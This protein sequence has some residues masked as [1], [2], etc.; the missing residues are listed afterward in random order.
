MTEVL[1]DSFAAALKLQTASFAVSLAC[2][3]R[4]PRRAVGSL[5]LVNVAP[6][7][8]AP[9]SDDLA[10]VEGELVGSVRSSNEFLTQAASHLLSAGGK[11]I[12]PTIAL[13]SGY[14]LDGLAPASEQVRTAACAV[15]LVH[16]GSL[17]HDDVIDEAATRRGVPTVNARW[18]NVVAI[19]AGDFL[20]AR[21]SEAAASLGA[22]VAALLA[23]TISELCRGQIEELSSVYRV[24]RTEDSYYSA[25]T[26][27][28]AALMATS[29]RISGLVCGASEATLDALTAFGHHTG[30][31]FQL[32]DDALDFVGDDANL[33]KRPGQDLAEGIYNLP[34]LRAL[35]RAP[36]LRAQLGAPI[37]AERL[38]ALRTVVIEAGGVDDTLTC[39]HDHVQKA[40]EALNGAPDLDE[41]VVAALST[42]VDALVD[43]DR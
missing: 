27:K 19:L 16:L 20:L 36:E 22:E 32:V 11:R 2:R 41:T 17:Y 39:A 31:C 6:P 10:Q 14:A 1:V 26:G 28:T 3:I 21:A 25:I 37:E 7:P 35:D 8:L 34:V 24:D 5:T 38:E 42:Y 9:L 4:P 33:G 15:E 40:L 23:E 12:R 43:R 13:A 18:S 29:A 30:M